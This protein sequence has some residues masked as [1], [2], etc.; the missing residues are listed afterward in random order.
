MSDVV[1]VTVRVIDVDKAKADLQQLEAEMRKVAREA[2]AE[3]QVVIAA[4]R[5]ATAAINARAG[6]MKSLATAARDAATTMVQASKVEQREMLESI[7]LAEA[8]AK[9]PST[10]GG[11]RGLLGDIGSLADTLS[12]GQAALG[13]VQA[14]ATQVGEAMRFAVGEAAAYESTMQ[15]LEI[16]SQRTGSNFAANKQI[17]EEF[18]DAISSPD[19][20]A[21]AVG[22]FATMNLSM[23]EQRK[24]I[25]GIRD[26]IVAMGGDVN[27]QLPLMAQAIKNG[28]SAQLENM[29]VVTSVDQM[30]RQ[31]A[32]TLGTTVDKLNQHQKEQAIVNGVVRESGTYAG[33]ALKSTD[34]YK[35]SVNNLNAALKDLGRTTGDE[36]L[37][38][39]KNLNNMLADGIRGFTELRKQNPGAIHFGVNANYGL[40]TD[41]KP[42]DAFRPPKIPTPLLQKAGLGYGAEG[43]AAVI[44]ARK[45]AEAE[46]ASKRE[47]VPA[48][49]RA[50]EAT[51]Q[52]ERTAADQKRL[53]EELRRDLLIIGKTG[54]SLDLA[55]EKLWYDERKALAHGND[56]LLRQ[57]KEADRLRRLAIN[58][59]Y[60]KLE[61]EQSAQ[62]AAESKQTEAR[63]A[64]ALKRLGISG[65]GII[66][67]ASDPKQ[68]S[69]ALRQSFEE[70]FSK[71]DKAGKDAEDLKLKTF[72]K[73][74][75]LIEDALVSG[76]NLMANAIRNG[77]APSAGSMAST[78]GGVAGAAI[79][80][81]GGPAGA[82][83]G[84]QIGSVAGNLIGAYLDQG[85]VA[86]KK[87]E[88][89]ARLQIE[90]ANKQFDLYL[91]QD[92]TERDI[93]QQLEADERAIA[94]K[95]D[96]KAA[97]AQGPEAVQALQHKIDNREK[98]ISAREEFFSRSGTLA[99]AAGLS[100]EDQEYFRSSLRYYLADDDNNKTIWRDGKNFYTDPSMMGDLSEKDIEHLKN[101]P[102]FA[103]IDFNLLKKAFGVGVGKAKPEDGADKNRVLP[104]SSP[105]TPMYTIVTNVKDFRDAF[106]ASAAYRSSGPGTSRRDG[107][108]LSGRA[109]DTGQSIAAG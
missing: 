29:G 60:D 108:S 65:D 22:T 9:A 28:E 52:A 80:L 90:A 101:K 25:T 34:T 83:V 63:N 18:S 37:P 20:V 26:G 109:A 42:I 41:G 87:Q 55:Q 2:I 97:E 24:L 75:D 91:R 88:D 1:T 74:S 50:N 10:G 5:E 105:Q 84:A 70:H 89:A 82:A 64:V 106:P 69:S 49:A 76:A 7:R 67:K 78:F 56:A 43:D 15:A 51:Q 93:E 99:S 45:E 103:N 48:A 62:A 14:A 36:W 30:Y 12:V 27:E 86:A 79:G 33:E 61:L 98:A 47:R 107:P 58:K 92:R 23:D 39:L 59:K 71:R 104:G 35:G 38:T 54:R 8:R 4:Q 31:Y 17:V 72:E 77:E 66:E 85:D 68:A 32:D 57:A 100:D 96:L 102:E 44:R 46:T 3:S 94:D 16:A 13:V 40:G 81:L 95:A 6:A 19:A 53:R 11:A 21:K 73:G